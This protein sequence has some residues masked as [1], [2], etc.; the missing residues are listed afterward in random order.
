L[1]FWVGES[2]D[3]THFR[4]IQAFAGP[5]QSNNHFERIAKSAP[6][7]QS[8]HVQVSTGILHL[9]FIKRGCMIV[10]KDEER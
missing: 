4:A 2:S 10:G 7:K 5:Q 9:S 3:I 6:L 8:V 1:D